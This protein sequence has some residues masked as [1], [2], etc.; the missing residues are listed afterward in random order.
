MPDRRLL[1]FLALLLTCLFVAG[2][3]TL[4]A[5]QIATAPPPSADAPADPQVLTSIMA[6][7]HLLFLHAPQGDAYRQVAL[8]PL[9]ALDGPR[10]LTPLQCQRVYMAGGEGLCMGSG[11]TASAFDAS[12]HVTNASFTQPGTPTRTRVAGDG[13]IGTMTW[14]VAGH[15]Y[16]DSTFSTQTLLVDPASGGT[17]ADL[18][19]FSITRDGAPL[20]AVDF[21]FW[22]V[23]FA[24]DPNRFYATLATGG[25]TYLIQGDVRSRS[26]VVLRENV[27][28]PSL[29]PDNTRLAFK[30][31]VDPNSP[32]EWRLAVLDL[33][34]M[35]QTDVPG[36]ARS[37]DDQV[38]WLDDQ[39]VLY[40]VQEPDTI[41]QNIWLAALDGSEAPRMLLQGAMSPSVSR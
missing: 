32:R 14:F 12:L 11:Q 8:V 26:A 1:V 41:R 21:N 2:A 10:Y 36:E 9:D 34:T 24:R 31:R 16:A 5:R 37:V 38:E 19:Q 30:V 28:C 40:A 25:K 15:S 13:S 4:R 6:R 3:Y 33:A 23:T 27:E 29:S 7:P 22:G 17:V 18:E 39:H 35:E 20:T